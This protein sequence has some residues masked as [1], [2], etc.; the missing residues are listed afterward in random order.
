VRV[1]PPVTSVIAC[2]H[3][4]ESLP[5][6]SVV[7]TRCGEP[8]SPSLA[9]VAA[10]S[11]QG[12]DAG[13]SAQLELLEHLREVTLGEYDIIGEL[14][15]GGMAT[16]YLGHDIALDRKVAIKVMH[17]SLLLGEGMADRFKREART[18]AALTHPH[19]IP[20]HLVRETPQ[21]LYFV[22]KYVEGR[23]LDTIIAQQGPLPIKMI[24]T[25]LIQVAGALGYAHR[26]GV[27]H[28]DV[29]PANIMID[30][31]GWAVVTDFG[32]AKVSEAGSLTMSGTT[33]GTPYY[34]SPEQCSAHPV[35]G[36]SDQYSLGVVGFEMIAGVLPF[37]GDSLMDVMR[38]HFFEPP[39][40]L[41]DLRPDCPPGLLRTVT[42]MLAKEPAQRWPSVEDAVAELKTQSLGND[43]PVR[44]QMVELARSGIKPIGLVSAPSSPTPVGRPSGA[45][46]EANIAVRSPAGVG[47]AK[48]HEPRT[49]TRPLIP[50]WL[51][52]GA[53]VALVGG[54]VLTLAI[55]PWRTD[56]VGTPPLA[57]PDSVTAIAPASVDSVTLP[58]D[59]PLVSLEVVPSSPIQ[60][61]AG[62][63]TQLALFSK[64][65]RGRR[66]AVQQAVWA[67]NDRAV[68]SVTGAGL[69][70][71]LAPGAATLTA[72]LDSLHVSVLVMVA[73]RAVATL[74]IVP[75]A[76]RMH[77]GDSA[78]LA[79]EARDRDGRAVP[80]RIVEW[81]SSDRRVAAIVSPGVVNGL[82]PG[83]AVIS[84]I[85][86]GIRSPGATITVEPSTP[87]DAGTLQLL[88]TPYATLSLDGRSWGTRDRF[89]QPVPA[90]VP[91]R[92]RFERTGFITIDTTVTLNAGETRLLHISMRRSP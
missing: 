48:P 49:R 79:A 18:A 36:A 80:G 19:I 90:G 23:S 46:P 53:A 85:S 62:Q 37:S 6:G 10:D 8:V 41:K 3:C 1:R 71:A 22:M 54:A 12:L 59:A 92:L 69:V 81:Q 43:D 9:S 84:A 4:S 27:V 70:R 61:E 52:W 26:R 28:R 25:V 67:S 5:L 50:V 88:I 57:A 66:S 14:G 83:N 73:R 77:V 40:P 32:I 56:R 20:I 89:E 2:P 42:R 16:V 21:I 63:A 29:K 65:G 47:G 11:S 38:K 13:S 17:P 74:S 78:R 64:D 45:K 55:R 30:S 75:S 72:A 68:A 24:E 44:T 51:R 60:L 31:E 33:V 86:E 58:V 34:M 76:V 82:S 35:T 91:H 15:R 7:C 87:L 39:P